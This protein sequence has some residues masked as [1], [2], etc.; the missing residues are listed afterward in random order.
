MKKIL[1]FCISFFLFSNAF[2]AHIS[3]GEMSYVYLGPGTLPGTLKYQVTLKLY[4]DCGSG[5]ASLDPIVT[6][7]VFNTA[8]STPALTILSSYLF[9]LITG[10]IL[11]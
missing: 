10:H 1:L 7:T 5:G 4:R 11:L 2:A 9:V 8:T 6:F 3:G